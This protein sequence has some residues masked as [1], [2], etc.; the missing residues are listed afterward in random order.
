MAFRCCKKIAILRYMK[1]PPVEDKWKQRRQFNLH[2]EIEKE[3]TDLGVMKH[4][5]MWFTYFNASDDEP[6]DRPCWI[7][8]FDVI[9]T[10]N[11]IKLITATARA[12]KKTTENKIII[13]T[14]K[15]LEIIVFQVFGFCLARFFCLAIIFTICNYA[16][17]DDDVVSLIRTIRKVESKLNGAKRDCSSGICMA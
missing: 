17:G 4:N 3:N 8:H 1:A 2:R 15:W 16:V 12:S 14:A 5:W 6:N 7:V 10:G 11:E 9:L 13:S